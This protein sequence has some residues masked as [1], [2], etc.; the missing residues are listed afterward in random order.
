M[1]GIILLVAVITEGKKHSYCKTV[2]IRFSLKKQHENAPV[3]RSC[4]FT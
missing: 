1:Q 2:P 4:N 3:S